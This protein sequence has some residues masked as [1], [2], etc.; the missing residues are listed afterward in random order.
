MDYLLTLTKN[1]NEFLGYVLLFALC[2]TGLYFTI[3]LGFVQIRKFGESFKLT[4]GGI[5][6]G[7]KAGKDGMSSFQSLAT[8]IAAQVGTGNLAGAAAAIATG[9]PGAIFWM[10]VSAFFGMATIYAEAT[11]AQ[12]FKSKTENGDVVGGPAYYIMAGIKGNLGKIL[13]KIFAVCIILALGFFGIM[14]QSNSISD[15]FK[16]A[17]GFN[18]IIVGVVI[19]IIILIIVLGGVKRIASITEKLVPAMALIYIIGSLIIIFANITHIP[20]AFRQIIVGAFNPTAAIGGAVGVTVKAAITYGV[21]RGLFSNE[22]GMG[23][24]PHAHALAK[25]NHPCEQGVVSMMGVFIDTFIILNLTALVILTTNS[26]QYVDGVATLTSIALT[27]AAFTSL[28]GSFGNIFIAI[29]LFFFALSTIIGWYFF[30]EINIKFLFGDKGTKFYA[31][32]VA[33]F[34]VLGGALKVDLVW[35]LSDFFNLL[36]VLP[37]LVGLIAVSGVVLALTKEYEKDPTRLKQ[38]K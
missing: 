30:G 13:A 31:I 27:Q 6:F 19:A 1:A 22:A 38:Q 7:A 9:G 17:F 14:V 5:K 23:S 35:E 12:K 3:R 20:E 11:A 26:L 4:F 15:S 16:T 24:T 25:V 10:W 8:A 2:G 21:K 28:F 32:I 29:C 37:N 33:I 36:M 34:I 18:P